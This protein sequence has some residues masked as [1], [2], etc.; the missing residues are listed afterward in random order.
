MRTTVSEMGVL[1][2]SIYEK[3]IG[4]K[5]KDSLLTTAFYPDLDILICTERG[6]LGIG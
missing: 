2:T 6:M 3:P 4:S 1:S 5:V